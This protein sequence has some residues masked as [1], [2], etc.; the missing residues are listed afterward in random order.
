MQLINRVILLLAFILPLSC[1]AQ[2]GGKVEYEKGMA[3][4]SKSNYKKANKYL[5]EACNKNY[6]PACDELRFMVYASDYQKAEARKKLMAGGNKDLIYQYALDL[7][8][9]SF[10]KK[11]Q[12]LTKLG[13]GG[14]K[15]AS[16]KLGDLYAAETPI[17]IRPLQHASIATGPP[18]AIP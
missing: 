8:A 12:L 16:L 17:T 4:L 7:P 5:D 10:A 6:L 3:Y 14:Y 2:E 13:E 18:K 15:E 1:M 9:D 11:V